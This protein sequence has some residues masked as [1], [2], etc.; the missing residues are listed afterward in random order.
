MDPTKLSNNTY[1]TK[2]DVDHS[3]SHT[4]SQS[5]NTWDEAYERQ[6]ML[7]DL[8]L[9]S[10]YASRA[11]IAF[12]I[13]LQLKSRI[14]A[15]LLAAAIARRLSSSVSNLD[16]RNKFLK[17]SEAY[18]LCATKCITDCYSHDERLA[19]Q[20]I[21]REIPLYGNITCMQVSVLLII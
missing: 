8:F 7:R 21:L 11:D 13:L 1:D 4:S 18:E 15:A 3:D 20:L 2:V 6:E 12:V 16:T 10:V 5:L 17:Q 14:G 9:W 19:C